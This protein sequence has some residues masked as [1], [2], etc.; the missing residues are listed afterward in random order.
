MPAAVGA[1]ALVLFLF[2]VFAFSAPVALKLEMPSEAFLHGKRRRLS[3]HQ[4][5]LNAANCS[6]MNNRHVS[7]RVLA[8]KETTFGNS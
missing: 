1:S 6:T 7:C 8:R 2:Y 3:C 4:L 5:A